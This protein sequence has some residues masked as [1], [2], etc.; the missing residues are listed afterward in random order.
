[1]SNIVSNIFHVIYIIFETAL[2]PFSLLWKLILELSL[3]IFGILFAFVGIYFGARAKTSYDML[4][5]L[6]TSSINVKII[7]EMDKYFGFLTMKGSILEKNIPKSI[8]HHV[9]QGTLWDLLHT[10]LFYS[11]LCIGLAIVLF[12]ILTFVCKDTDKNSFPE[13]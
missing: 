7:T 2:T 10:Y 8:I 5:S 3:G 11:I 6:D 12:S 1:V 4:T 9:N 13:T